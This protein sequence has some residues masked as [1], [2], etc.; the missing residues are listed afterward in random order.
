ML[1]NL[2]YI[3]NTFNN[4]R[5]DMD[6]TEDDLYIV[7]NKLFVNQKG[8]IYIYSFPMNEYS[9]DELMSTMEKNKHGFRNGILK[10]VESSRFTEEHLKEFE[11][12]GWNVI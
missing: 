1:N 11:S 8:E 10:V 5:F 7:G 6:I 9:V 3:L 12:L 2:D 4:D